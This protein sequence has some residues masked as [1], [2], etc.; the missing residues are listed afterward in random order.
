MLTASSSAFIAKDSKYKRGKSSSN[1]NNNKAADTQRNAEDITS[2]VSDVD[3]ILT[4]FTT[5]NAE[6][7]MS[8]CIHATTARGYHHMSR[9]AW[10]VV[11][12][13]VRAPFA[14]YIPDYIVLDER[15]WSRG[16]GGVKLAG[17]WNADWEFDDKQSFVE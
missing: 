7:I 9:L 2:S 12:P 14:N 16:F 6:S 10:P 5:S 4:R 8:A 13:M 11:P 1:N 3:D 17:Y 15:I